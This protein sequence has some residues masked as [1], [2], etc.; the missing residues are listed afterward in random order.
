[1]FIIDKNIKVR[2][3]FTEVY[4]HTMMVICVNPMFFSMIGN[5]HKSML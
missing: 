5:V 3:A 2:A 4:S 1:M